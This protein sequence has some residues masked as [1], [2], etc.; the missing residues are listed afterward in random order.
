MEL[1]ARAPRIGFNLNLT[2]KN[3]IIVL[4]CVVFAFLFIK[5]GFFGYVATDNWL[6]EHRVKPALK[7]DGSLPAEVAERWSGWNNATPEDRLEMD[8]LVEK[9]KVSPSVDSEIKKSFEPWKTS[10]D[11]N[12]QRWIVAALILVLAGALWRFISQLRLRVS[13]TDATV[14]PRQG[15]VIPWEKITRV[16]NTDWKSYGIVKITYTDEQGNVATA[17]FDDYKTQREPLLKILDL[18]SEKAINAEF[19]PKE[20]PAPSD[21]GASATG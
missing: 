15:L 18:L 3:L 5:D 16:D 10:T 6:V 7:Q 4:M 9:I 17:E 19:V 13:A 21:A 20:D 14:S 2:T 8:H 11:I 1:E 12:T